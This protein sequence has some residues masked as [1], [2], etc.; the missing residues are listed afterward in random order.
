MHEGGR[1]LGI[2]SGS[3]LVQTRQSVQAA[4]VKSAHN[5]GFKVVA[6]ALSLKDTIEVLEAGVDGLA[7]TFFDEPISQECIDLYVSTGA[8][9]NP[10]LV[11]AGTLTCESKSISEEFSRDPRVSSR[12]GA[13]DLERMHQCLHMKSTGAKWEYAIDSVRQLRAAGVDIVW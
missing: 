1:A 4:V 12:V 11:A 7:H 3:G 10:T 6:H 13:D 5:K 9:L 2:G 8:W